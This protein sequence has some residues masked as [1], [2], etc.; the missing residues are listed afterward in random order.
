MWTPG[1]H[2]WFARFRKCITFRKILRMGMVL[3]RFERNFHSTKSPLS[4]LIGFPRVWSINIRSVQPM[5]YLVHLKNLN[6][7]ECIA[8]H[9]ARPISFNHNNVTWKYPFWPDACWA[10]LAISDKS[11]T[12]CLNCKLQFKSGAFNDRAKL[13]HVFPLLPQKGSLS[14]ILMG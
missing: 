9:A 7:I 6:I 5:G 12:C 10:F 11:L 1:T 4:Q 3:S 8:F 2:F 14:S 13:M